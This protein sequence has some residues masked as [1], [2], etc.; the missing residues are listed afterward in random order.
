[1]IGNEQTTWCSIPGNGILQNL[2]SYIPK[3]NCH[4]CQ[5]TRE[6]KAIKLKR[7]GTAH[8]FIASE[9]AYGISAGVP[10]TARD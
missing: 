3:F 10:R 2:K 9:L 7:S 5:I 8:P 6:L 4:G 1:L